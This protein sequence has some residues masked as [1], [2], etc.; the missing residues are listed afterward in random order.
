MKLW[1]IGILVTCTGLANAQSIWTNESR[2]IRFYSSAADESGSGSSSPQ[3][4]MEPFVES[5]EVSSMGTCGKGGSTNAS[6]LASQNSI[7][8]DTTL[9][10]AGIASCS[11]Y[12]GSVD[13]PCG[14][15]ADAASQG[16]AY[17]TILGEGTYVLTYDLNSYYGGAQV[18][19]SNVET[20]EDIEQFEVRFS[21]QITG[22]ATGVL[23]PGAYSISWGCAAFASPPGFEAMFTS[24]DFSIS[25]DAQTPLCPADFNQ[26]GGVDGSDVDAFFLA[27]EA[28]DAAA[29]TNQD[30]GVDGSDVDSFFVVWEAG[31]C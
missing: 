18:R 21:G 7:F 2:L 14:A 13:Y 20:G 12:E 29:D 17:F 27:W 31:G 6:A 1:T 11:A 10:A 8:G 15:S 24:Y 25:I 30:G 23:P 19:L 3:G 9:T 16:D 22:T 4:A 28:G 26:D 5:G